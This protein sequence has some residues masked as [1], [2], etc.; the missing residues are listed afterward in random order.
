MRLV[1]PIASWK[2]E[3]KQLALHDYE[4]RAES[5][6]VNVWAMAVTGLLVLG[7]LAFALAFPT[8]LRRRRPVLTPSE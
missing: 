6:M 4:M 2:F 1:A 7:L 5:R 3:K 8:M